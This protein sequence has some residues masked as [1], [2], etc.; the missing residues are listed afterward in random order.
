M[1]RSRLQGLQAVGSAERRARLGC[2]IS[3]IAAIL[4]QAQGLPLLAASAM[5]IGLA[6]LGHG[7]AALVVIAGWLALGVLFILQGWYVAASGKVET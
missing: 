2:D 7:F 5:S 4:A 6:C 3:T 1:K